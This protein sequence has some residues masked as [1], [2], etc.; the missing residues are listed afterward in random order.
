[1]RLSN[2]GSAV[3]SDQIITMREGGSGSLILIHAI[4]GMVSSYGDLA[5]TAPKGIKVVALEAPKNLRPLQQATS[6]TDIANYY[7]Q[8]LSDLQLPQPLWIGGWC[9]GGDLAL[10]VAQKLAHQGDR[11]EAVFGIDSRVDASRRPGVLG[12]AKDGEPFLWRFFSEIM[13]SSQIRDRLLATD[14]FWAASDAE[15]VELIFTA[16][17]NQTSFLP[18]KRHEN[19]TWQIDFIRLFLETARQPA[20]LDHLFER[21]IW[22]ASSSSSTTT[23]LDL[24]PIRAKSIDVLLQDTDHRGLLGKPYISDLISRVFPS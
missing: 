18:I 11:I 20:P 7:A 17:E 8:T 23:L 15:R 13:G 22:S 2:T 10:R 4:A 9:V 1:M 5:R 21:V 24:S 16:R 14:E 19:R 12:Y 3:P 6:I